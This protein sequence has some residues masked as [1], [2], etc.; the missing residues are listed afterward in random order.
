MKLSNNKINSQ[1]LSEKVGANKG[2]LIPTDIGS[3]VNDFLVSNFK[4]IF[5]Y[6][7]TAKVEQ[8]FDLIA[9]GSVDWTKMIKGFYA[10]FHK[11]VSHVN[12]NV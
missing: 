1:I 4:N 3:I 5:D 9:E 6:S 10:N 11:T 7:F 8:S 12:E 2:K